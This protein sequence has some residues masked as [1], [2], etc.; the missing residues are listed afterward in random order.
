M[1]TGG[2]ADIYV[3]VGHDPKQIVADFWNYIIGRPLLPPIFALGWNQ[4]R[5]GYENV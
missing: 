3:I 5:W 2:V 4:C 1:A